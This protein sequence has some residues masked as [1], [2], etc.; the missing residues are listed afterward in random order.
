MV[1]YKVTLFTGDRA[2]AGTLNNVFIKLVGTKGESERKWLVGFKGASAF[3]TGAVSSF[4]VRSPTSLG[5][6]VLVEVDKKVLPLF[7]EDSW[8]LTKVEVKSPDG[9]TF[10]FPV[11]R[12]ISD[13]SVHRFREARALRIFDDQHHLG[14]YSREQELKEREE[15]YG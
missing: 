14:R 11:H 15:D 13:S 10:T 8:F 6:L 4:T 3:I 9:D 1:N 7:P 12:W 5:E 2:L